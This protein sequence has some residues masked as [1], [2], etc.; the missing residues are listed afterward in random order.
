MTTVECLRCLLE[1]KNVDAV[2]TLLPLVTSFYGPPDSVDKNKL[3][4]LQTENRQKTEQLAKELKEYGKPL[5]MVTRFSF[6]QETVLP[7][8]YSN[9]RIPEYTHHARAAR[10]LKLLVWYSEYLKK[11]KG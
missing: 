9:D 1:D 8:S 10:V 2:L 6:H 3:C 5:Y 7:P 11:R 4:G